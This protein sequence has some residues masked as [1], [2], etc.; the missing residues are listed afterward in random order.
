MIK[1]LIMN[2]KWI[3]NDGLYAEPFQLYHSVVLANSST[4]EWEIEV[5]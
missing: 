1:G 3:S 4:W 5:K 2:T